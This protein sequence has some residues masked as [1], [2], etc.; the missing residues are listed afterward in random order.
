MFTT[1]NSIWP[2]N[3]VQSLLDVM[4]ELDMIIAWFSMWSAAR[5][6]HV[7][8]LDR[9][10]PLVTDYIHGNYTPYTTITFKPIYIII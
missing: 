1:I 7:M 3:R 5:T 4:H 10:A 9:V 2:L 6:L 8:N